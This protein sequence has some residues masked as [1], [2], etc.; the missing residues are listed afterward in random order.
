M[1]LHESVL[2]FIGLLDWIYFVYHLLPSDI[3]EKNPFSL[4]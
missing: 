3:I 4:Q 2:N 1:D